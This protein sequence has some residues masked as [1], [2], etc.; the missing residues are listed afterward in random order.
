MR[1]RLNKRQRLSLA[2][3]ILTPLVLALAGGVILE[4]FTPG[5]AID[6]LRTTIALALALG[7]LLIALVLQHEEADVHA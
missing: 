5:K 6:A 7:S 4:L 1:R 3:K 2:Q